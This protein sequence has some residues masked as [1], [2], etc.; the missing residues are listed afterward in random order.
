M[1]KIK[2]KN[3]IV[4]VSVVISGDTLDSLKNIADLAATDVNTVANVILALAM[5]KPKDTQ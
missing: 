3:E 1:A 2:K 5:N 4:T